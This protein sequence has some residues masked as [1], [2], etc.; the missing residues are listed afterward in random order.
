MFEKYVELKFICHVSFTAKMEVLPE[1][2]WHLLVL[3]L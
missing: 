1:L 3:H 2:Q